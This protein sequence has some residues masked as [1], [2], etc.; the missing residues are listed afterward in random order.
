MAA[1][2]AG[3]AGGGPGGRFLA[4]GQEPRVQRSRL[5]REIGSDCVLTWASHAFGRRKRERVPKG[6][7]MCRAPS[8]RWMP[9]ALP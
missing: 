6:S 9:P 1:D 7:S 2:G 5:G 8:R 4:L 3:W